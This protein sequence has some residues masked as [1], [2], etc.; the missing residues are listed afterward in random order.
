VVTDAQTAVIGGVS[1]KA[2]NVDTNFSYETTTA[3]D[4][5]YVLPQLPPGNYEISVTARH[6]Q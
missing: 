3:E 6:Q 2:K 1:V 4:G 5:R